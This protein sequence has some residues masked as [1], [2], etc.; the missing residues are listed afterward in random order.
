MKPHRY[1][2]LYQ[3]MANFFRSLPPEKQMLVM[4]AKTTLVLILIGFE[5][6]HFTNLL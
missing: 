6:A 1:L 4:L 5:L 2:Y 3:P